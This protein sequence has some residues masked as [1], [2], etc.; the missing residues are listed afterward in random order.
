[1][2]ALVGHRIAEVSVHR[3][4]SD[5]AGYLRQSLASVNVLGAS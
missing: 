3:F 2:N 5:V 1:M 4:L